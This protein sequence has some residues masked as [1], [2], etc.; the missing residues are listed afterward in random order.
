MALY[1]RAYDRALTCFDEESLIDV[2]EQIGDLIEPGTERL[3]K[4]STHAITAGP[5]YRQKLQG[6]YASL[7]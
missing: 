4:R 2:F 1:I 7:K 5:S 6:F 3:R